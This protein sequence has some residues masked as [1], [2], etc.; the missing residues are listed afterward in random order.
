M[1]RGHIFIIASI[2]SLLLGSCRTMDSAMK[3]VDSAIEDVR[4]LGTE[5]EPRVYYVA[6]ADLQLY[7][8]PSFSN[9]CIAKL[10][11][12]EKV[13]R[14]RLKDGFAYVTVS[15]TGQKG[16]VNNGYLKWKTESV[17]ET[18]PSENPPTQPAAADSEKKARN[19]SVDA[20]VQGPSPNTGELCPG[21][22]AQKPGD[23][24]SFDA[25]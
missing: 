4:S 17:P 8:G 12:N 9:P 2:A 1:T 5:T 6:K 11:L 19:P 16:W 3:T 22:P 15:S 14:Y 13:T 18:A 25:F 24:S 10:P 20:K 21:Q 23:A 7:S